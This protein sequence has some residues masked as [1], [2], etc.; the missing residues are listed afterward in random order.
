MWIVTRNPFYV[1]VRFW[2]RFKQSTLH[3]WIVIVL[4]SLLL[5]SGPPL[6]AQAVVKDQDTHT[7]GRGRGDSAPSL[8]PVAPPQAPAKAR[9]YTGMSTSVHSCGVSSSSTILI[10]PLL[11]CGLYTRLYIYMYSYC[12]ANFLEDHL[13]LFSC[14]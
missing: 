3:T 4:P 14:Q 10:L 8:G 5:Y 12:R 1:G 7:Q 6:F 9:T 2:F 13:P 11:L